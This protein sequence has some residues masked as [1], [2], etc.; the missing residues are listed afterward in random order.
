MLVTFPSDP[1]LFLL[2]LLLFP[3]LFFFHFFFDVPYWH[4]TDLP[5]MRWLHGRD[6]SAL[7]RD[8]AFFS[9]FFLFPTFTHFLFLL[10]HMY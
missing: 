7:L 8:W 5:E 3:P 2:F 1:L 10:Y 9:L 4:G 6:T